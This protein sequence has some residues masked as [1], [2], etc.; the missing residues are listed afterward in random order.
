MKFNPATFNHILEVLNLIE[1][2]KDDSILQEL[3]DQI[4]YGILISD[5]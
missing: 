1:N 2:L 4:P 3:L 5:D